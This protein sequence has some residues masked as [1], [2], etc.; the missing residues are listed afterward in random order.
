MTELR[1]VGHS[2]PRP[3]GED[4][5]T[6][7]TRYASDLTLPGMAVGQVLRLPE[8]HARIL[9]IDTGAA[10]AMPGVLAV[11]T[12]ADLGCPVPRFGTM[13]SDQP[14]LADGRI[15]Y[16]GEPVAAVAAVDGATA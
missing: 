15:R 6:G 8:A 12:A 4:K 2:C 7:T 16:Q 5:V 13:V 3:D 11:L 1:Y 10:V 14:V 9:R